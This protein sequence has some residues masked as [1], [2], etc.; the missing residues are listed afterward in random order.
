MVSPY[1]LTRGL[2]ALLIVN[3]AVFIVQLLPGIG[4]AVTA[5]GALVPEAVYSHGQVW[6]FATYM[7]LH[8]TTDMAHLLLNMLALWMFG[9]ELEERWGTRKFITLYAI[10]GVGAGLFGIFYMFDPSMRF[11]PVIGASGAVFGLLTAFAVYAPKRTVLL[12]FVLPMQAWILVAG[13]AVLSLLLAFSY[14]KGIAHLVHFGGIA[15][16]FAY[17]NG[18]PKI[19]AWYGEWKTAVDERTMRQQAEGRLSRKRYFEEKVDPIL[20]KISREG[21]GSLTNEERKIL[22]QAGKN[23]KEEFRNRK[24]VPF[25]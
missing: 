5:F 13:Y 17:L 8:S 16:A 1:P 19:A 2:K 21:M 14:G 15:V 24:I 3:I 25:Q 11:I 7:F 23:N 18:F 12:F 22:E 9:G 4:N 10:F 6:R 20:Q